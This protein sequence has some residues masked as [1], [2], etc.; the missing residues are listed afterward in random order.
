MNNLIIRHY[1]L[2]LLG[3][4]SLISIGTAVFLITQS[5]GFQDSLKGADSLS[6]QG[7]LLLCVWNFLESISKLSQMVLR[8]RLWKFII[9]SVDHATTLSQYQYH[10]LQ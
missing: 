5:L 7:D 8:F 2:V 4:A 9:V 1:H 6:K 10:C 3:I